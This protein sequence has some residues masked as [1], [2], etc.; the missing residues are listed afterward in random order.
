MI[1]NRE[2][3]NLNYVLLFKVGKME[4]K[5]L[6]EK[7]L[8]VHGEL[9]DA[10]SDAARLQ[11]YTKNE[12]LIRQG[13]A[14]EN[15]NILI[16]GILAGYSYSKEGKTVVDCFCFR[17]GDIAIPPHDLCIP[18]S[19]NIKVIEESIVVQIPSKDLL[20]ILEK[21]NDARAIYSQKLMQALEAH[22]YAKYALQRYSGKELYSWFVKAYPG[23]TEK[24]P[25]KYIA[26]FLGM[27][28]VH[29]SCIVNA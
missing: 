28:D 1:I 27:S 4:I 14:V 10:L 8:G 24:V 3:R 12:M 19:L 11:N 5:S 21:F 23:L 7:N 15:V 20:N 6:I 18:S 29:F 13:E 26:S 25:H 17:E 22:N 16:E 9:L 2:I